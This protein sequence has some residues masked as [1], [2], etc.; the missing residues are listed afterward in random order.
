MVLPQ[1]HKFACLHVVNRNLQEY[2]Q[3]WV[4]CSDN[5]NRVLSAS[6]LLTWR[7]DCKFFLLMSYEK[8]QRD[9]LRER[10]TENMGGGIGQNQITK[11]WHKFVYFN[12]TVNKDQTANIFVISNLVLLHQLCTWSE[13]NRFWHHLEWF[14]SYIIHES[15]SMGD[16]GR[17]IKYFDAN[18]VLVPLEHNVPR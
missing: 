11:T 4:Q 13:W 5:T 10:E 15:S 14:F 12:F 16:I 8:Q 18:C 17:N 9:R 3:W 6:S 2:S 7:Q 1:L